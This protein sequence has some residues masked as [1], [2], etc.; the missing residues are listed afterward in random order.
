MSKRGNTKV[1]KT[2]GGLL[3]TLFFFS[4]VCGL[5][6]PL[7]VVHMMRHVLGPPLFALV[8]ILATFLGG[9]ALGSYSAGHCID[10]QPGPLKIY[11]ILEG[12]L[13]LYYLVFPFMIRWITPVYTVLYR[14]GGLSFH[15]SLLVR[16]LVFSPL[17][18]IPAVLIGATW[19]VMGS[20]FHGRRNGIGR[21]MGRVF[22]IYALGGCVGA[23][24]AG[25]FMLPGLGAAT[26]IRLCAGI[27]VMICTAAV[28]LFMKG[29]SGQVF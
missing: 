25:L 14:N 29:E 27:D 17:L 24:S 3:L 9:V 8:S 2:T 1:Q 12:S 20:V 13:G 6:F 22:G 7:A 10:V 15:T 11:G 26:A 21:D 5:A 16:Y 19:P 23:L 4:G 18:L 28:A